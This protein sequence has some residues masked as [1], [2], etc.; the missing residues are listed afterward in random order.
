MTTYGCTRNWCPGAPNFPS[1]RYAVTED[2]NP[3]TDHAH[4]LDEQ[5]PVI[6]GPER[7]VVPPRVL[8]HGDCFGVFDPRGNIVP[9]ESGEG[10][11]YYDGTRFLS[12][13]ELLLFG[14]PPMLLSSTL[15]V[16]DAVFEA[17][18]TNP[19]VL[20]QGHIAV[21]RGDINIHRSRVLWSPGSVE[22]IRVTNFAL[23]PITVPLAIRFDSDFA[24]V[25][26][27]RGTRRARRGER[28]P[29][30]HGSD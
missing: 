9:S 24:D 17:D 28:L 22:R 27:V 10:G 14:H 5:F 29:D 12:W 11:L 3:G 16:D 8:K 2:K 1:E 19:D 25:F 4:L 30:V 6:A 26:E 20:R 7:P 18:L 13:F 15:G 21:E 23:T